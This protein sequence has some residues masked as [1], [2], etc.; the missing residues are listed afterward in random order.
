MTAKN[1]KNTVVIKA[2]DI[3]VRHRYAP[4]VRVIKSDKDKENKHK[5][6]FLDEC[7]E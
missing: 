7:D 3:K 1:K 4:G 5:K 2:E 6:N